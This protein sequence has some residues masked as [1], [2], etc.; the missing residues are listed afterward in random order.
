MHSEGGV[1]NKHFK[2][3]CC[4]TVLLVFTHFAEAAGTSSS[5]SVEVFKRI[6]VLDGGRIKPLET[7]ARNILLQFSGRSKYQKEKAAEWLAKLLFTPDTTVKDKVFLINNT[8]IPEALGIAAE[9]ERR[10]HFDELQP[11][12][13]KLHELAS[14]A[15]AIE[16]KNRDV[17]EQELIR[18]YTNLEIYTQMSLVFAFA[19]PHEDFIVSDQPL[20]KKLSLKDQQ[21][22]ISF[23][24]AAFK[25]EQLQSLIEP[26]GNGAEQD[27]SG[28]QKNVLYLVNNLYHWSVSYRD[29]PVRIIPSLTP[30][31]EL[32]FS[33]WDAVATALKT[34]A[35]RAELSALASMSEAYTGKE[36]VKFDLAAKQFIDSVEKRMASHPSQSLS[37]VTLELLYNQLNLLAWAKGVYFILFSLF[38][39]SLAAPSAKLRTVAGWL[40][41]AA[42]VCH[43]SAIALRV[44]ILH[45]P[46]V[47]SLYETFVFVSFVCCLIGCLIES[48]QKN[49]MGIVIA[50]IAGFSFLTI[51]EKFAAEGDTLQMLV[52]VLNSNFWLSTHVLS[53][54]TGYAGTCVAALIGHLYLLQIIFQPKNKKQLEQ[55]H[56]NLVGALGFSL[57]MT[58]LG[59][60][61]GGIW[62]DQSWGRFWGWDPKENGALMI[63]LWVAM[64]FHARIARLIGPLGLAVGSAAGLMVVIWAWFGVN[65]LSVGLHSYGFTSGLVFNL[66]IYYALQAVILVTLGFLARS[67]LKA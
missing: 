41:L 40:L 44:M 64:L 57:T 32:W 23:I 56:R 48:R 47:S 29:L 13:D 5:I 63:I 33:P 36:Q 42:A 15:Q 28:T 17:I 49:W 26:L 59:T 7:F 34:T 37:S 46:P 52:A 6:P 60:N 67:K 30:S 43:A 51:A 25:A 45:R 55:T 18:L 4:L 20:R 66:A 24:E 27:W 50:G 10:Y 9:P 8:A 58:F 22:K 62:A 53:I 61:L 1:L 12:L 21:D 2:I 14:A 65:L 3:A 39:Y 11:S 35:G 54:T 16:P 38:L 31:E 19:R